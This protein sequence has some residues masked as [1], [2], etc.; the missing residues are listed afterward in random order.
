MTRHQGRAVISA[1]A[2]LG[3]PGEVIWQAH[4]D[5]LWSWN[6]VFWADEPTHR[7]HDHLGTL[8]TLEQS[9]GSSGQI[10]I[11]SLMNDRAVFTGSGP[12]P[13]KKEKTK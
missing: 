8:M 11:T 13:G 5:G 10:L 6:G 9:D 12:F 7:L 2:G 1:E 4:F 3:V